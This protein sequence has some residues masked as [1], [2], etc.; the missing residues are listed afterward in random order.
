VLVARSDGVQARTFARSCASRARDRRAKRQAR[1]GHGRGGGR[2]DYGHFTEERLQE[3]AKH[4]VDQAL[5]N[6]ESRPAPAAP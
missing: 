2:S 4:A 3:Y 6:L 5:V 1:A